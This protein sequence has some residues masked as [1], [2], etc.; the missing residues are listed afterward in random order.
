MKLKDILL[1]TLFDIYSIDV[2]IKTDINENK[3]GIY[4]HIRAL[5]GVVVVKVEQNTYLDSQSSDKF[6]YSLLHVK[7]TTPTTPEEEIKKIR[8]D[9][10]ITHKI[11]GL[12]QFIPRFK[13]I[14]K[15][16][17]Y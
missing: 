17:E 11:D 12:I 2:L 7:Y 6:E 4:N 15:V 13:T 8:T 10:L 9:A 3:V 16:G 1:E 5:K 14:K